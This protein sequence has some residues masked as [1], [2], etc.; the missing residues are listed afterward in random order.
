[1]TH[2]SLYRRYRSQNFAQIIGQP[3]ITTAL[4]NAV[5]QNRHGHAYLF[6]GPRGT[7]KTSTARVL[8][9]ALNCENLE[10]GEPC[11]T[12]KSCVDIEHGTSFDLHELDAASNNKVDDVR[13]L[14][15]KVALGSP[16]RTKV[17]I[18]DEVHMLSAGAENALLKTLEEP[19]AHVVFVLATTE[20]HKVVETIR[21][22]TQHHEFKLLPA[23]DLDKHVRWVIADAGLDVDE[24]GIEFSL[25]QGGGSA[26]DTLSALDL[27]AAG[28]VPTGSD[29][30]RELA[31]AIGAEDPN[32]AILAVQG[33]IV[34]GREP[35]TIGE[36]TLRSLRNGFLASMGAPLDQLSEAAQAEAAEIS[37]ELGARAIT[38]SLETLGQALVEMRQAPDPRVPLEVALLRLARRGG[39]D[40][41]V[42]L[43]R[44]EALEAQVQALGSASAQTESANA[45]AQAPAPAPAQPPS[46]AESAAP[47][48]PKPRPPATRPEAA[49]PEVAAP[50]PPPAAPPPPPAPTPTQAAPPA[51]ATDDGPAPSQSGP[52]PDQPKITLAQLQDA[53]DGSLLED[54]DQRIRTRFKS[55][56]FTSVVDGTAVF[57]APNSHY[58]DRVRE[59]SA[60][61]EAAIQQKLGAMIS[62]D[63]QIDQ[64]PAPPSG[65]A[66]GPPTGPAS[67]QPVDAVEDVGDVAE[68]KPADNV[69]VSGADRITEAFP[70]AKI[71]PPPNK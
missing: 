44:I 11:G 45:P 62:I 51:A 69:A 53:L 38:R 18:L 35:R 16:G 9:K 2:Q 19:P 23:T 39:S 42:L 47:P 30:G 63:I 14:I 32:A 56:R 50:P 55:G 70:G 28:G 33:A 8:A 48:T 6:S 4:R 64:N 24:A 34:T 31:L 5:A 58:V 68:L 59:V 67:S 27:V 25:R 60:D 43:E 46:P 7:G 61:V 20:P 52:R 15:A 36:A 29:I 37:K 49:K 66:T 10:D 54:L 40:S 17:Y 26:R 71:V 41:A 13:D 57:A 21:S 3:H 65:R 1:V 12:C 22:R